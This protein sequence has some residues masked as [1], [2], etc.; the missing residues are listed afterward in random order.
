[1]RA[2]ELNKQAESVMKEERWMDAIKLLEGELPVVKKNWRLSRNLGWCYFKID[3]LDEARRHLIQAA[4]LAP[5]IAACKWALG[6]VY[7]HRKQ[8]KKAKASLVESLLIKDAH[9][10]RISLTLT[11]LEQGNL[12]EAESVHLEEIKLKPE[13]SERY[14]SYACF[15]SDV[16]RE[17]EARQMNRKAKKVSRAAG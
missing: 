11:Y 17:K 5:E 14:E 3:R 6:S 4:K 7:L 12:I 9:I 16:G 8:Y 1:M 15:L 10:A 13:D 2:I